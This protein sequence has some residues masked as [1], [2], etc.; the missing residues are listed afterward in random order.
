MGP[1]R[2]MYDA[3]LHRRPFYSRSSSLSTLESLLCGLLRCL[4]R[5]ASFPSY[6]LAFVTNP[7]TLIWLGEDVAIQSRCKLANGLFVHP[8][9]GNKRTFLNFHGKT[10]WNLQLRWMREPATSITEP[11]T[12]ARYPT[13]TISSFRS[14][15]ELVPLTMFWINESDT[16]HAVSSSLRSSLLVDTRSCSPST[17]HQL[18]HQFVASA[19]PL[20]LSQ[21]PT[22]W[23]PLLQLPLGEQLAFSLFAT[24]LLI[25]QIL[26][27][28]NT[29]PRH[30]RAFPGLTSRT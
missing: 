16:I 8:S 14:N 12:A 6:I 24:R 1:E 15:P 10:S 23:Q 22:R 2:A 19:F 4:S 20:G 9:D 26:P 18:G 3:L 13:P 28:S 30:Q 17:G 5:L 27:R 7:L 29:L 11:W 25:L 21:L